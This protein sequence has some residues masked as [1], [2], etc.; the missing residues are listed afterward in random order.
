VTPP[1]RTRKVPDGF[2]SPRAPTEVR[3]RLFKEADALDRAIYHAVADTPTPT[4]DVPMTWVS[5][6]ANYSRLWVV[7]A[8]ALAVAGGHRGRRAAIRGLT[9]VGAASITAN[10]AAKHL[11]PRRRPT[12]SSDSPGRQARMP[13]SSSFPSGHTASAFAF[14][15]AVTAD[16]PQLSLRL[17]GLATAVGYSRVHTGVHYPSDVMGGGVLGLAVGTAVREA[18]LRLGPLSGGLHA[19]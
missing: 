12:R 7:I 8:A 18:T 10:L 3:R 17:Y 19:R 2:E 15:A 9:A 14:A 5:N 6:A 13:T 1:D 11:F 16:F 4:L